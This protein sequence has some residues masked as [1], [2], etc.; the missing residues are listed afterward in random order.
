M[1]TTKKQNEEAH[2]PSGVHRLSAD[3]IAK[4]YGTDA[5]GEEESP[6]AENIEVLLRLNAGLLKRATASAEK[7]GVGLSRYVEKALQRLE[8]E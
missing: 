3:E 6:T 7:S 1:S 4:H 5:G 8:R 2:D